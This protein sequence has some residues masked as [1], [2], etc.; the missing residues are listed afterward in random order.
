ME[1]STFGHRTLTRGCSLARCHFGRYRR[2]S[3][4]GRK[5]PEDDL[6]KEPD[7]HGTLEDFHSLL[8]TQVCV[9]RL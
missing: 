1:G 5:S 4:S 9:R 3:C 2:G 7:A 8:C 6:P